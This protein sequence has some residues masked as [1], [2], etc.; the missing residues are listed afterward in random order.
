MLVYQ[1]SKSKRH[2][3]LKIQPYLYIWKMEKT[4]V[5]TGAN[6]FLAS[7]L[8]AL[9]HNSQG[10]RF[11]A[12]S[13][14]LTSNTSLYEA[15]YP[16]VN[17][18]IE[19]GEQ[20]DMIYFLSAYI[21]YGHFNEANSE[22]FEAN[23]AQVHQLAKAY[24]NARIV[25]AS[26]VSVYGSSTV[27]PITETTAYQSPNY[28]GQSKLAGEAACSGFRSHAIIRFTSLIGATMQRGTFIPS[29][30][31]CAKQTK[32]IRLLGDG[33]RMQSYIDVRDAANICMLAMQIDWS[34]VLL[35]VGRN[36]KS[37]KEIAEIIA[38]ML[39]A[40]IVYE[41]SDTSASFNYDA[42]FSWKILNFHPIYEIEETLAQVINCK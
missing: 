11:C 13:R 6:G 23:A 17:A 3:I 21:P 1:P 25:Y 32:E 8:R 28:Y 7:H 16:S 26:S 22:L 33:S 9:L 34:G 20:A 35:G 36:A 27:S 29:I 24:P 42:R 37:N 40:S 18:F 14:T 12:I 30:I 39:S 19:A 41:G 4:V 5:I 15:V 2:T 10:F 31:D 38:P